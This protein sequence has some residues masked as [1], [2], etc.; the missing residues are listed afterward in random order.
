MK[1]TS[2]QALSEAFEKEGV[3]FIVVGGLAVVAHG[4]LRATRDADIVIELLPDNI[5]RAFAALESLG[6]RPNIPVSAADLA[7]P[8]NRSSWARDRNMTVLQFWSDQHRATPVDVFIEEPFDFESEW[9]NA[10]RQA[11]APGGGEIRFASLDSLIR[12]KES[13]GRAQDLAD[14]EQLKWIRAEEEGS[15]D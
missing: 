5:Q 2:L 8:E 3:R 10:L 4:Y 6:Y 15:D 9:D 12:M 14:V 7:K 11:I 13:A 1:A